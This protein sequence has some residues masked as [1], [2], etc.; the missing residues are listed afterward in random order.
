M[1]TAHASLA[2]LAGCLLIAPVRSDD[3]KDSPKG[4]AKVA[5]AKEILGKS[6]IGLDKALEAAQ[7]KVPDGKP[8]AVR[9]EMKDGKGRFGTYFM[10]GDTIKEV[11]I[12]AAT[13]DVV[14]SRDQQA[15]ERVNGETLAQAGQAQKGA[16]ISIAQAID[17]STKKVKDGKPFEAE[18]RMKSGKAVVEV[19]LLTGDRVVK[20]QVDATDGKSVTVEDSKEK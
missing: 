10:A 15:S 18:V 1:R 5:M 4:E 9:L 11:E 8:L 17:I 13:G 14:R 19:E 6:N 3:T 20:V 7:K 16:T 12:D 2:V